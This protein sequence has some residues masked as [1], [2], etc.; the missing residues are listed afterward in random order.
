[1]DGSG[2]SLHGECLCGAVEYVVRDAFEYAFFCHC[3]QCRRT[4]GSAFKPTAG[5]ARREIEVFWGDVATMIY[6]EDEAHDVHCGI[7]GSLLFSVVREG[8]YVHVA[9]GTLK[10]EPAIKPAMHIFV[11]S[12][13]AWFAITDDLP[14]HATFP[15][16]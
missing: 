4:T 3:S 14:Q 6:G 9:M 7:C 15:D 10:D 13:A 1:M 12:K 2:R 5:I 16:D 8:T 11:G